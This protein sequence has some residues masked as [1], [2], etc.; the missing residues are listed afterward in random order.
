MPSP[1]GVNTK[2]EHAINIIVT[3]KANL[4]FTMSFMSFTFLYF[5]IIL[6]LLFVPR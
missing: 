6:V 2:T 3:Q 1:T 5:L 4:I